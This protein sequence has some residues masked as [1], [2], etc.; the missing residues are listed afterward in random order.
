WAGD[1]DSKRSTNAYAFTLNGGAI[2]WMSKRQAV[3]ALSTTKAEYMATTHACKEA[4]WLKR[5]CSYIGVKHG[6]VI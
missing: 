5:L 4:I 3:V 6:I 1:V 2:S